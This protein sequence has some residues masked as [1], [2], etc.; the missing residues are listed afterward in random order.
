MFVKLLILTLLAG[1]LACP[2]CGGDGGAFVIVS[3]PGGVIVAGQDY[4]YRITVANEG[5][6]ATFFLLEG[7]TG[8]EIDPAGRLTWSPEYADLGPHDVE[9]EVRA[10]GE[11]LRQAWTLRV[12]QG[13]LLGTALSPRGHTGGSSAQDFEEH[14]A[15][16]DPWG[17]A[18]AF[19]LS[20]RESGAG[21][22][23]STARAAMA[24]SRQ[25]GFFPAIGFGWADGAGT[26][27]LASASEPLNNSWSNQETRALFRI[28]VTEFA[29]QY[30]PTTLF[31]GNETNVYYLSHTQTEWNNWMSELAACYAAI[32]LVSP[33]T[34]V[35]TTFQY[36]RLKGLGVNNGW[37]DAPQLQLIDELTPGMHVDGIGFTSYPYFEYLAPSAI[38]SGYYQEIETRWDG[39]VM[40]TEI[41]WL[42]APSGPYPGSEG[43]QVDF[44]EVFFDRSQELNLG[45]VNWLFL[46]DWDQQATIP[47]FFGIG[48]RSNDGATVREVDA[49]WQAAVALRQ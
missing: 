40:F 35:F 34:V 33:Q 22:I 16:H 29:R 2:G 10:A 49:A 26:P 17:R 24:A 14:Y 30:R 18:I 8:M 32:K 45:Y 38:P 12:S 36:E 3:V 27:D 42:A 11:M 19:H 6:K 25:Y 28:M 7:P 47:A 4:S 20:W 5:G 37:N 9:V 1:V 21:A 41:G 48:L 43:H 13:V 39:L 44:L 46:H 31:L 15:N 23:P